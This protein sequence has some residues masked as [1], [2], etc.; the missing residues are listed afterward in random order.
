[1]GDL[2]WN[3]VAGS[4]LAALLVVFG[5]H[6]LGHGLYHAHE[7]DHDAYPIALPDSEG[8]A[9]GGEEEAPLDLGTLMA[10]ADA[11]AGE[12]VARQC[13]SCHTFE[14]GGDTMTGP[15]LWNVVGRARGGVAGFGYSD[16]MAS[17]GGSWSYEHL[18]DFLENPRGVIDGTSMSFGGIRRE[19][20]RANLLAYLSTLS[21][22]PAPFPAPGGAA[23][24]PAPPAPVEP[25][26]P[27]TPAA[28][29]ETPPAEP[30][31]EPAPEDAAPAGEP[32]GEAAPETPAAPVEPAPP[33]DG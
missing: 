10:S 32:E 16:A 21:D 13:A 23:A 27:A 31:L 5:V 33:E 12:R 17:A 8:G 14:Q 11:G 15:N 25:A 24:E 29:V 6:L 4:V 2:F 26:A 7:L 22:S 28:V 18:F 9:A 1:M 30:A 19:D 20:Q 3:K